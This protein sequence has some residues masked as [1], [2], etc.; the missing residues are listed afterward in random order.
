MQNENFLNGSHIIKGNFVRYITRYG[1]KNICM[2]HKESVLSV[3]CNVV[4]NT[5]YVVSITGFVN[6]GNGGLLLSF[7]G[8]NGFGGQHVPVDIEVGTKKEYNVVVSSP[9]IPKNISMFLRIFKPLNGTGSVFI[10]KI[11]VTPLDKFKNKQSLYKRPPRPTKVTNMAVA[12][13]PDTQD[14]IQKKCKDILV[15]GKDI[16]MFFVSRIEQRRVFKHVK[17]ID[18]EKFMYVI[19]SQD[20]KILKNSAFSVEE[21]YDD[22]FIKHIITANSIPDFQIVVDALQPKIFVGGTLPNFYQLKL[23]QGCKKIFISHGLVGEHAS[24]VSGIRKYAPRWKGS[25]VYC[26]AG[27]YLK[28]FV[29]FMTDRDDSN[30]QLNVMP[31]F[32]IIYKEKNNFVRFKNDLISSGRIK[33]ASKYILFAGFG[34]AHRSDFVDHNEDYYRTAIY[35]SRLAEKNGWY[36]FIKPRLEPDKD[37]AFVSAHETLCKYKEDYKKIY[38]DDNICMVHRLELIY[39]YFFCDTIVLNGT[40]TVEVEAC[41]TDKP[42]VIVRTA[43]SYDPLHTLDFGVAQHVYEDSIDALEHEI[44]NID[45]S[46]FGPRSDLLKYHHIEF[47]GNMS[48]RLSK[49]VVSLYKGE[50]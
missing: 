14:I 31:Q 10:N 1:V 50:I 37:I 26:G 43:S 47:D 7:F 34:G 48:E 35:L 39:K 19:L 3:F 29:S 6:S 11:S 2:S 41:C 44:L 5:K 18:D 12:K 42:L 24:E 4:P 45:Y 9:N 16:I 40:S 17:D 13:E 30:V 49:V 27:A 32:D 28:E 25:D 33:Q 8:G 23:P 21:N 22:L 20:K 38:N 46:C 36:V 15:H